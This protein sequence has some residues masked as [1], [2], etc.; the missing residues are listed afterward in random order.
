MTTATPPAPHAAAPQAT[1]KRSGPPTACGDV[2]YVH[3]CPADRHAKF[4]CLVHALEE[5]EPA[6]L[7][8]TMTTIEG[9]K[10]IH[11]FAVTPAADGSCFVDARYDERG[12]KFGGK[13]GVTTSRCKAV[14]PVGIPGC[15]T[16][17]L[18][19]C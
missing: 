2:V 3:D 8:V 16:L 5:C 11:D 6:T 15:T 18:D 12:D 13:P 4:E 7:R 19:G 10:I 17:G 1:S 9:G 14:K